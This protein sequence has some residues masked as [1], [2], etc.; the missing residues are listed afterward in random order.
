MDG[1]SQDN[2]F[3]NVVC[4]MLPVF[5]FVQASASVLKDKVLILIFPL[6]KMAAN[7]DFNGNDIFLTNWCISA[8]LEKVKKQINPTEAEIYFRFQVKE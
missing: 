7:V 6:T 5:H 2:A 1:W 4:K 8:S 3:E